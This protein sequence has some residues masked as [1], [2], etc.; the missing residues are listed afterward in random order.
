MHLKVDSAEASVMASLLT[1]TPLEPT[2]PLAFMERGGLDAIIPHSTES[3][4][5]EVSV[6]DEIVVSS[7]LKHVPGALLGIKFC[8]FLA[9]LEADDPRYGKTIVC[10][11]KER[12]TRKE[13]AGSSSLQ[14]K[15]FKN[16]RKKEWFLKERV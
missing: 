7:A 14:E 3:T 15:S 13:M 10:L 2:Q 6:V 12:E 5:E 8:D 9:S 11:L 1:Q 16:K 4:R